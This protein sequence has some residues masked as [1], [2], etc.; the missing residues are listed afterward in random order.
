MPKKEQIEQKGCR[1][2]RYRVAVPS[3]GDNPRSEK[4]PSCCFGYKINDEKR[5]E[6]CGEL[7]TEGNY[8]I[9]H[10]DEP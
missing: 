10:P 7:F 8:Y 9:E 6:E 2:C 3:K 4:I 1:L 5:P